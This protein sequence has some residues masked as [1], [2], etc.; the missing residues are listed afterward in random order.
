VPTLSK[1][2]TYWRFARDLRKFLKEPVTLEQSR[3]TV[4]QRLID[5]EKN[6]LTI[7]KRTIYQN[8]KSP[9]LKLLKL[10]GCEYGDFERMVTADGIET[11]LESLCKKGVYVT[12]EEFKG[13]KEATRG[14]QAFRFQERDFDN[15]FLSRNL[16]V[17]SSASRSAGTRTMYDF[18]YLTANRA[19]ALILLLDAFDALDVPHSVCLPIMPGGGPTQ[20]LIYAK[21][22]KT[23]VKWFSPL[24][25]SGFKPSLRSRLGNSYIVYTGRIFGTSF[26]G[27]EFITL[28]DAW[29]AAQWIADTIKEHGGCYMTTYVS[30]AVMICQAAKH[31]GLDISG[32]KFFI[33]GEPITEVKRAEVESAGASVCPLYVFV[34]AGF[35]GLGCL[36][37]SVTDE[38]HFL[39]DSF[40]LIQRQ[41]EVPHAGIPVDAFL[42]TT[43]L[44]SAPKVLLNTESGDYGVVETRSCGCKLDELGFTDHIHSIRGFDKLTSAGVT[45]VGT[46]LLRIIEEILPAKFGGTSTDYQMVEEEDERGHTRM[47]IV[48]SPEVGTIDEAELMGTILTELGKGKDSQQMMAE[49]WSQSGTIQVKRV[50]P[51]ATAGG[52]LLPLHIEKKRRD[53]NT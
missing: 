4:R 32:I 47:S 7:V 20:L 48:V 11:T 17:S 10:A 49:V 27:P 41:R 28:N 22:G 21:V 8:D 16:E 2:W 43:L 46:D 23:P 19:V 45:F 25:K 1:A 33:G 15:P 37:Q 14:S 30:A 6:L 42:F 44:P 36:R 24:D 31:E 39:K 35:V 53:G 50:R 5:R 3:Q 18:D 29:P 26:P 12:V 9:Y 34:E 52:K 38:V 13:I 51:L 40:A